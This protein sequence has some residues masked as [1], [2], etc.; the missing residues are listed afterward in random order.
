M[1]R[2]LLVS[3]LLHRAERV[4]G[5]RVNV[6]CAGG[7]VRREFTYRELGSAARRLA[8]ALLELGVGPGTKVGSLAWN[9]DRHLA[10]YFGVPGIGAVLH[11]INQRMPAEHIV[12]S[13]NQAEDEVL[14]VDADLV[15]VV[16]E[17]L[18]ATPAVKHVVV[19]GGSADL[20]G[21]RTWSFDTLLEE[22]TELAEFPE[23]DERTAS[24]ICFTSGTTGLPKGVVYTHR[25]TVL[26]ALAI[27]AADGVAMSGRRGYL[28]ACQMSHVHSWGAPHAG[29]LQGARLILPGPHPTPADFLRIITTQ[30]PDV[31]V[32]APAVAALIRDEYRENPAVHDLSSLKTV[33]MGGQTPPAA[34][35]GWWASHGASTANG[36][37]MTETSPMGTFLDGPEDQGPPLPL[38]EIRI[39][40]D[41]GRELPWDGHTTGELEARGHWVT[42]AYLGATGSAESFHDGW[43]RTGDVAVISP[44]GELRIKDRA[45]DLIKSGGEWISSIELENHLMLHPAVAEA[46]VIGVPHEKWQERPIAWIVSSADVADEE[47]KDYVSAKFPR[48]WVPDAFVRVEAIPKTSI[49]KLDKLTM[50]ARQ[51]AAVRWCRASEVR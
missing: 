10:A 41:A 17:I 39:V 37:G 42:G 13:V 48:Y 6:S 14:L 34:L 47:L 33:W 49:G 43:L 1:D 23:F 29:T 44:G 8:A 50:R 22:A 15:P 18:P 24:S 45:K 27:S 5:D 21:V 31:L 51:T 3:S 32:G 16:R 2:P 9:S 38:F 30:A 26:H 40:D 11:T 25:S 7:E 19:L 20:P 4:F 35:A 28:I 36:W 46:A 12:Y